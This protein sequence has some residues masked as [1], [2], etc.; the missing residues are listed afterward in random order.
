[1][2]VEGFL[3]ASASRNAGKLALVTATKRMSYADLD[4]ASDRL[5]ASL[6]EQGIARGD[7]VIVFMENGWEA[8][9]SIFAI[10]KAGAV[11]SPINPS[12]KSDKLAYV[13]RN[14]RARAV[15]TQ[16]KLAGIAAEAI[17]DAPSVAFSVV[18]GKPSSALPAALSFADCLAST[19]PLP[20]HHGIDGLAAW[21][22]WKVGLLGQQV[23]PL[24]RQE[25]RE[26]Q[27]QEVPLPDGRP[28]LPLGQR[29]RIT[30]THRLLGSEEGDVDLPPP[31]ELHLGYLDPARRVAQ[32]L[33][34]LVA[35]H[36]SKAAT[37]IRRRRYRCPGTRWPTRGAP[38]VRSLKPAAHSVRRPRCEGQASL[39]GRAPVRTPSN[40]R[41][42]D[43]HGGRL[44]AGAGGADC[45]WR[46]GR[47]GLRT[48]RERPKPLRALPVRRARR[49]AGAL[50]RLAYPG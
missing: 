29:V 12:T 16:T 28:D 32:H 34:L 3:R 24:A 45:S 17:A 35:V 26:R 43:S 5:A 27:Q 40:I 14:C 9:A 50:G 11:F 47:R 46:R 10:L 23:L 2:R 8:V 30:A 49:Y 13:L 31:N 39:Q 7:R 37:G 20:D 48:V 44:A 36:D 18:A 33:E 1:M 25:L 38:R 41:H 6:C 21:R 19:V 15:L 4:M 22:T 42:S